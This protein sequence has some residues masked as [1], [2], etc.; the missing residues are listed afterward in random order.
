MKATSQN[1]AVKAVA[2]TAI[3]AIG[4]FS[5][6]NAFDRRIWQDL[7]AK[8]SHPAAAQAVIEMA[9]K[10]PVLEKL[11]PSLLVRARQTLI[12]QEM[13]IAR[14]NARSLR[15]RY[16]ISTSSTLVRRLVVKLLSA[17]QGIRQPAQQRLI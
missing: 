12:E 17:L 1:T 3:K 7:Y 14:R 5:D 15:I 8:I 4:D 9:D 6:V 13:A 10:L 11:Y 2:E 16:V